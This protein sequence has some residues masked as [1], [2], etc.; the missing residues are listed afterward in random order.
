MVLSQGTPRNSAG[1]AGDTQTLNLSHQ[2]LLT[3][4]TGSETDSKKSLW[5]ISV[6][7]EQ[8]LETK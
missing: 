4:Q 2:H 8:C 3:E 7:G 6:G 1:G 5:V